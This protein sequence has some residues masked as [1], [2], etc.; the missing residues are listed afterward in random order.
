MWCKYLSTIPEVLSLQPPSLARLIIPQITNPLISRKSHPRMPAPHY[1]INM[2]FLINTSLSLFALYTLKSGHLAK[3]TDEGGEKKG[4]MFLVSLKS[5][6]CLNNL[7]YIREIK[8]RSAAPS[9][10][11][12]QGIWL[13]TTSLGPSSA[14]VLNLDQ[15]CAGHQKSLLDSTCRSNHFKRSPGLTAG[16]QTIL[17]QSWKLT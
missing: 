15:S 6:G 13:F 1:F 10:Q 12:L 3:K 7:G 17:K 8:E 2:S 5:R 14:P 9:S 16:S 11:T 4:R